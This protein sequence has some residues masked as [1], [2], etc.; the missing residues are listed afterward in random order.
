MSESKR[1]KRL[2]YRDVCKKYGALEEFDD[3]DDELFTTDTGHEDHQCMMNSIHSLA[4]T[5]DYDVN[6]GQN[7]GAKMS[8]KTETDL[9]R[10]KKKLSLSL[11]NAHDV[12]SLAKSKEIIEDVREENK[13][14]SESKRLVKIPELKVQSQLTS[15]AET[16]KCQIPCEQPPKQTLLQ[17]ALQ[18]QSR[19]KGETRSEEL[20]NMLLSLGTIQ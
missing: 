2:S 4:H 20:T 9:Y 6:G 19:N 11:D 16:I 12:E 14:L 18:F 3:D 5:D 8:G 13:E 7:V 15:L 17:L 10:L 1:G